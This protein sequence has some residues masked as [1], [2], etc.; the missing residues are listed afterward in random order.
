MDHVDAKQYAQ[1]LNDYLSIRGLK[2][3]EIERTFVKFE[4]YISDKLIDKIIA[5]ISEIPNFKD[6][7][8]R[9]IPAHEVYDDY[10]LPTGIRVPER[11]TKLKRLTNKS[12][13]VSIIRTFK[14]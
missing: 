6:L 8:D 5:A 12:D 7:P 2:D 3:G 1:V 9:V 11:V 14:G 10:N 13:I 4:N